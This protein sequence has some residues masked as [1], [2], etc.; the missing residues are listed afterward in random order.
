LTAA[1]KHNLSRG[2]SDVWLFE[3]GSVIRRATENALGVSE[4]P[5]VAGLMVG[6]R[7]GWLKSEDLID[8]YDLKRVVDDLLQTF[9]VG[10]FHFH[11]GAEVPFLHPGISAR[12]TSTIPH[13]LI[14]QLH[15]ET[16]KKLGVEVPVFYFELWLDSFA[17]RNREIRSVTP[18]RFPSVTRDISFW[19][20]TEVSADFQ[21]NV[22]THSGEPLLVDYSILEDFRD[23]RYVPPG[24]KGMLWSLTYRA[25]DR[26]LTDAEVDSAHARVV[27]AFTAALSV[28]IR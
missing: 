7:I 20:D 26:T 8:Y 13:G 28:Q 4:S 19:I 12:I 15:P 21:K 3:V 9:S 1:L 11:Q 5:H 24:K 22:L 27:A 6:K 17:G 10:P 23:A 16:V 2:N 25:V 14:G 18:P